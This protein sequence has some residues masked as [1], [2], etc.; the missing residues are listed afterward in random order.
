M[1]GLTA[2]TAPKK[3]FPSGNLLD[4]TKG[5]VGVSLGG[6]C[7]ACRMKPEY[8]GPESPVKMEFKEF[9]AS[10]AMDSK[11]YPALPS[12]ACYHSQLAYK[13]RLRVH[14]RSEHHRES[15]DHHSHSNLIA[16]VQAD[17]V[18]SHEGFSACNAHPSILFCQRSAG[19]ATRGASA[20]IDERHW[21]HLLI[22]SLLMSTGSRLLAPLPAKLIRLL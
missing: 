15:L 18:G 3:S 19:F 5:K 14:R 10:N 1:S 8:M 2:Y 11:P 7:V 17:H 9:C 20:S 21:C 6:D 16:R 4:C 12:H 22:N 13:A